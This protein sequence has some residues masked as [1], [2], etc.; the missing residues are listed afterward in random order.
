[1]YVTE[2]KEPYTIMQQSVRV[3]EGCHKGVTAA[4]TPLHCHSSTK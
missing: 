1:M 4:I 3:T 2:V